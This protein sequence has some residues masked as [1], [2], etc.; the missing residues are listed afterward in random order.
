MHW[1]RNPSHPPMILA[2]GKNI[3]ASLLFCLVKILTAVPEEF[4]QRD[5]LSLFLRGCRS[6]NE[7][8]TSDKKMVDLPILLSLHFLN[9]FSLIHGCS[10]V[11]EC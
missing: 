2:L 10:G 1:A 7:Y 9:V 6:Y 5:F 3:I 4:I 8:R 11:G